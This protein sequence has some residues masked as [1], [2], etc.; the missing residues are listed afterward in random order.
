[1][2]DINVTI[3]QVPLAWEDKERNLELFSQKIESIKERTDLIVL[4]EMFN[5]GFTMN[6]ADIPET[7][8]GNTVKWLNDIAIKKKVVI[9]GSLIIE[10]N[11]EFY[12][13][14]I[15]AQPDGIIFKYDKRHLFRMAGEHHHFAAGKQELII[16]YH[17]WNF[18]PLVCYD[19]RFPVWSRN[20]RQRRDTSFIPSYDC[21]VY[22]ANWPERRSYAWKNLLI[23]RAIEN[24]CYVIGVNRIGNDGNDIS[25]SGDSCIINPKG[26]VISAI[27]AHEEKTETVSLSFSELAEFRK[28]FP[29]IEDADDFEIKI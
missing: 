29:V 2:K 28:A 18:K 14:F 20:K 8:E 12:N 17:N 27:S 3:I 11:G 16:N 24:Q 4:P 15:W 19:L 10:E 7:M 5:S 13:R 6:T 1:M 22:V 9:C 21:L 25:Y 23:A 26:E